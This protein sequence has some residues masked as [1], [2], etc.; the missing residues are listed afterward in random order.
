MQIGT[1]DKAITA[2]QMVNKLIAKKSICTDCG[3]EKLAFVK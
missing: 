1:D 3:S 2:K